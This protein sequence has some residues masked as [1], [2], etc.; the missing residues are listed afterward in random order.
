MVVVVVVVVREI[1]YGGSNGYD[2]GMYFC[3]V[4]S[5]VLIVVRGG[6]KRPLCG[7]L[8]VMQ[9]MAKRRVEHVGRAG[10]D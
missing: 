6:V 4:C 9:G 8:S 7:A 3:G 10:N 1:G 2:V 5:G